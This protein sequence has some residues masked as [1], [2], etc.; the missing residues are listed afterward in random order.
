MII[1]IKTFIA[2]AKE[3]Y[4]DFPF[5][6]YDE[7]LSFEKKF[8]YFKQLNEKL[9]EKYG[10]GYFKAKEELEKFWSKHDEELVL[11]ITCEETNIIY[12]LYSADSDLDKLEYRCA[13]LKMAAVP[14]IIANS[15]IDEYCAEEDAQNSLFYSLMM[16][17]IRVSELSYESMIHYNYKT[18]E[19]HLPWY[20][21]ATM[22]ELEI[23]N[24]EQVKAE[25][26]ELLRRNQTAYEEICFV[27]TDLWSEEDLIDFSKSESE[28]IRMFVCCQANC[29]KEI[30]KKLMKDEC[31]EVAFA[32]MEKYE[33]LMGRI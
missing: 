2:D 30:A 1:D 33:E 4:P 16:T 29:T 27:I 6:P 21:Q 5:E 9:K 26:K 23:K 8:K 31:N 25:C 11:P 22:A 14:T 7:K 19:S 3:L 17:Q 28:M 24:V 15:I 13:A 20:E 10:K 18:S 12:S 32:A